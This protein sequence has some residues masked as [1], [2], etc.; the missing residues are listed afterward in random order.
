MSWPEN[1]IDKKNF[2]EQNKYKQLITATEMYTQLMYF[3]QD[4]RDYKNIELKI[5][6]IK[7]EDWKAKIYCVMEDY[8]IYFKHIRD[9]DKKEWSSKTLTEQL[10]YAW[11]FENE[12]EININ[13][14]IINNFWKILSN[15]D[16]SSYD[17]LY[18]DVHSNL[19]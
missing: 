2:N 11:G 9:F 17:E 16:K 7:Y 19:F 14:D 5:G 3:L 10:I 8:E 18:D 4:F 13:F 15:E 6:S 12:M 1:Y